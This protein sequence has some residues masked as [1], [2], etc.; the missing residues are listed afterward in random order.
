MPERQVQPAIS[1]GQHLVFQKLQLKCVPQCGPARH[2]L[3]SHSSYLPRPLKSPELESRGLASLKAAVKPRSRLL[4]PWG[5]GTG[6][7][8]TAVLAQEAKYPQPAA[9]ERSPWPSF[10][11]QTLLLSPGP[12]PQPPHP[13]PAQDPPV[14]IPACVSGISLKRPGFDHAILLLDLTTN[15]P[16]VLAWHSMPLQSSPAYL[17]RL[18]TLTSTLTLHCLGALLPLRPY[19]CALHRLIPLPGTPSLP[20]SLGKGFKAFSEVAF[21]RKLSPPAPRGRWGVPPLDTPRL[22]QVP[23]DSGATSISP[24]LVQCLQQTLSLHSSPNAAPP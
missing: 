10:P 15:L 11:I 12:L 20:S 18:I 9:Q 23:G 1:S 3:L 4:W 17:P 16:Q 14:P 22:K 13:L 7:G 8:E 2:L 5:H 21:S 19:P 6:Q 24:S